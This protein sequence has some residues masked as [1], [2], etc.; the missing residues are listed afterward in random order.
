MW[1]GYPGSA[2]DAETLRQAARIRRI[3]NQLL[4]VS[5]RLAQDDVTTG[6]V[7]FA[8]I[9]LMS[10]ATLGVGAAFIIIATTGAENIAALS[11]TGGITVLA[12]ASVFFVNPVQTVERDMVFRRWSD[13]ISGKANDTLLVAIA[14]LTAS[15]AKDDQDAAP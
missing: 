3:N 13:T 11:V 8:M 2:P 5:L 1:P 9:S 12:L 6:R 15:S 4:L 7:R 10:L 14:A